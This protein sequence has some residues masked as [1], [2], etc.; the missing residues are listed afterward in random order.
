MKKIINKILRLL[1]RQKKSNN[2]IINSY[3]YDELNAILMDQKICAIDVGGAVNLQPHFNK[4]KY[5][6]SHLL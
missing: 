4:K 1:N 3:V 6:H 2:L 5:I